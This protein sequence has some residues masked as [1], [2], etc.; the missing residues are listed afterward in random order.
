[1]KLI[2]II[3]FFIIIG[4]IYCL[5]NTIEYYGHESETHK[6]V[7][8]TYRCALLK[9]CVKRKPTYC[10]DKNITIP[11]DWDCYTD[12]LPNILP[13]KFTGI[14]PRV[15]MF[16]VRRDTDKDGKLTQDEFMLLLKD[17]LIHF[18]KTAALRV[19]SDFAHK[20]SDS[21]R[22][23]PQSEINYPDTINMK[24]CIEAVLILHTHQVANVPAP[25][26]WSSSSGYLYNNQTGKT[27][28]IYSKSDL[29]D[30]IKEIKEKIPVPID[31]DEIYPRTDNKTY[32]IILDEYV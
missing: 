4:T 12:N 7:I 10:D 5:N 14:R 21:H 13:T 18:S 27:I 16:F 24:G 11:K 31:L 29:I 17:L 32:N 19:W 30:K 1:M 23:H 2:N 22:V 25:L 26:Y 28:P 9:N 15:E 3:I 6:H 20:P 8:P